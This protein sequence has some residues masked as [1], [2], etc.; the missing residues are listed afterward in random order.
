MIELAREFRRRGKL[1]VIGGPYASLNPTDMQPHADILVTGELEEISDRLFNDIANDRWQGQY[2]GTRPDLSKS[3]I[4]R[5]DLYPPHFALAGQVQTSRGCPFECEFCDVIQYLGRKQRWKE[6][7]QVI[8]ELD[9]LYAQGY[10]NIFFADDNLTVMR[11][12]ARELLERI[13]AWNLERAGSPVN[14]STQVSIDIARDPELLALGVEAGLRMVFIGIESPNAESLAETKKRQNLRIDLSAQ[15][16]KVV[17]SGLMVLAGMIVGFDNDGPDIFERQDAFIASLPVP[18]IQLGVLVAPPA[19]PLYARMKSEGR[20]VAEDWV[21]AADFLAS[22]IRPKLMTETQR[23]AGIKWLLNR[24]YAPSAYGRRVRKFVETNVVRRPARRKSLMSGIE[25]Q[26]ALRLARQGPAERALVEL[27]ET[28]LLQRPDL[29]TQFSYVLLFYCQ[30]RFLLE[31]HDL[32][33]P[34]LGQRE[35]ALAS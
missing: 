27:L 8:R 26:L 29:H 35:L 16:R 31:Q 32:W 15:V 25:G 30:V 19:T 20:L 7:D 34:E 14:F 3:P 6:P 28:L 24:I 2:E 13:R 18:V 5:W 17:E 22:N 4:P 11:R 10:R 9:V 23:S 33:D 21:G 1:V 12:R